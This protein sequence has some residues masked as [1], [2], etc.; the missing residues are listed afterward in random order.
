MKGSR[1]SASLNLRW[2][3][4]GMTLECGWVRACVRAWVRGSLFCRR[5]EIGFC[6]PRSKV[7]TAAIAPRYVL[8][9]YVYL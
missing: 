1:K 9:P 5:R 3:R 8:Q 4:I 6:E 2:R 7:K